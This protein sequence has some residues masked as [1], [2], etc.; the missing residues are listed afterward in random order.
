MKHE[1]NLTKSEINDNNI[2]SPE[3]YMK[4]EKGGNIKIQYSSHSPLLSI[5]LPLFNKIT[6]VTINYISKNVK[7]LKI[8][9][10]NISELPAIS[11]ILDGIKHLTIT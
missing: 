11:K 4:Y 3:Y 1:N 7:I 6:P 8:F 10:T 9:K 5:E 2:N